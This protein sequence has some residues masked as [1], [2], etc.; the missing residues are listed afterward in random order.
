MTSMPHSIETPKTRMGSLS[1]LRRAVELG[2][3][4]RI[5]VTSFVRFGTQENVFTSDGTTLRSERLVTICQEIS[6]AISPEH[7]STGLGLS[8]R[9]SLCGSPRSP[10]G[11]HYCPRLYGR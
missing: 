10:Q 7:H 5:A 9:C 1:A 4:T 3:Q 8:P 11:I 6:R 2:R